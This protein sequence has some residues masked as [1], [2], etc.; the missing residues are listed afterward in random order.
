[1]QAGLV[2]H[3]ETLRA[4]HNIH[5]RL[6]VG[7]HQIL[8]KHRAVIF[9]QAGAEHRQGV[10]AAPIQGVHNSVHELQILA[11]PVG[12][13]EQ[14]RRRGLGGVAVCGAIFVE[15]D[16]VEAA[17]PIHAILRQRRGRLI[18]VVSA[19]RLVTHKA[20]QVLH[21][22]HAAVVEVLESGLRD[23]GGRGGAALEHGVA[24]GFAGACHKRHAKP[25][26][27]RMQRRKA[28][29]HALF[30]AKQPQ[31]Q[32]ACGGQRIAH[33]AVEG[34]GVLGERKR[35]KRLRVRQAARQ[36]AKRAAQRQNVRI[37]C[38]QKYNHFQRYAI[39]RRLSVEVG[40]ML[41]ECRIS[42]KKHS[43]LML[44]S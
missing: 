21:I 31:Q 30:A 18:A 25:T 19:E 27:S 16:C 26:A 14:Q 2:A 3:S 1:M 44:M 32:Q 28:V 4:Y 10:A 33:K 17:R 37:R 6:A 43:A 23:D 7:I 24:C 40:D 15:W 39:V 29:A 9:A 41:F 42:H 5:I 35:V 13:V 34:G 36:A 22:A 12:A 8:A 11:D 38:G 20:Q